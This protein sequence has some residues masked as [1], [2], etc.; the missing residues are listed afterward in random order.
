MVHVIINAPAPILIMSL[1]IMLAFLA[2]AINLYVVL[3][4]V[5]ILLSWV[6]SPGQWFRQPLRFLYDITEPLLG[7]VRQLI[8]PIGGLDLSPILAFFLLELLSSL[9]RSAAN[10]V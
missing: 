8:P 9:L 1:S 2:Q 3:L 7:A 4:F 5:R 6:V 10:A